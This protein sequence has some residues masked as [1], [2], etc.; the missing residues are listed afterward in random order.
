MEISSRH[1]DMVR[2]HYHRLDMAVAAATGGLSFQ[3]VDEKEVSDGDTL[4]QLSRLGSLIQEWGGHVLD[5]QAKA[6]MAKFDRVSQFVLML[7]ET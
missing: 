5:L 1:N 6:V 2:I 3:S 4:Y 7:P